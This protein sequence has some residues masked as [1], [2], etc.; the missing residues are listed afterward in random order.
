MPST[1]ESTGEVRRLGPDWLQQHISNKDNATVYKVEYQTADFVPAATVVERL[2]E[3]KDIIAKQRA[4]HPD[5]TVGEHRRAILREHPHMQQFYRT[6]KTFFLTITRPD[7]TMQQADEMYRLCYFREMSESGKISMQEAEDLAK[8]FVTGN[9][10]R[11]LTAQQQL[12]YKKTGKLPE[13]VFD[14]QKL[15][16]LFKRFKLQMTDSETGESIEAGP[17]AAVNEDGLAN[18]PFK[19][20]TIE[21]IQEEERQLQEKESS[22]SKKAQEKREAKRQRMLQKQQGKK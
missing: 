8:S 2:N 15:G 10:L 9:H 6:H 20:K 7:L 22:K 19:P 11:P 3:L 18:V 17:A 12:E 21:E 16:Y 14:K 4:E 13:D 5:W 1:S